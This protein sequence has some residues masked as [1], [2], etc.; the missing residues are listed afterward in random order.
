MSYNFYGNTKS[1]QLRSDCSGTVPPGSYTRQ[2]R[3]H[4]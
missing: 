4:P 3:L 1:A 2:S